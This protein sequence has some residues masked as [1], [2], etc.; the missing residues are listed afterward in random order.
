MSR[1]L[2]I[3]SDDPISGE[4]GNSLVRQNGT[5]KLEKFLRQE[6]LTR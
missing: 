6:I 3:G 2:V 1:V 4:I 5:A